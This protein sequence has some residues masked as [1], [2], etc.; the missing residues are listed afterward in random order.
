[1][2]EIGRLVAS[3]NLNLSLC[4]GHPEG[5]ATGRAGRADELRE[6]LVV[7]GKEQIALVRIVCDHPEYS[8][9]PE[10]K[11]RLEDLVPLLRDLA[12]FAAERR[13]TLATGKSW[14]SY[15]ADSIID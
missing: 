4:W 12:G 11:T 7:A 5:L 9:S 3:L 13:I 1:M 8:Y 2:R 10:E 15:L 6:W 14:R